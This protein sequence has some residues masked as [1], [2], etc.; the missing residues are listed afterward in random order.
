MIALETCLSIKYF[1]VFTGLCEKVLRLLEV[2]WTSMSYVA[3]EGTQGD[4]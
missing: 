2:L 4:S 1:L 3:C